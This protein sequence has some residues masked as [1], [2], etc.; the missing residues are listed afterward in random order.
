MFHALVEANLK[1]EYR[2]TWQQ[3]RQAIE[4]AKIRREPFAFNVRIKR[5]IV[6][7]A[8]AL[9]INQ[10]E[11]PKI[12]LVQKFKDLAKD[13]SAHK[14]TIE[15]R[16]VGRKLVHSLTPA[17]VELQRMS[18]AVPNTQTQPLQKD[19][20][21]L[22]AYLAHK[23]KLPASYAAQ[24]AAAGELVATG[25]MGYEDATRAIVQDK[26][27]LYDRVNNA[28]G[29]AA[30]FYSESEVRSAFTV[31]G[32]Y[33]PDGPVV[34]ASSYGDAALARDAT[35]GKISVVSG[36]NDKNTA[37]I[38]KDWRETSSKREF[39]RLADKDVPAPTVSLTATVRPPEN[40]AGAQTWQDY[41]KSYGADAVAS[42]MRQSYKQEFRQSQ[43]APT[44]KM[45]M[46]K[47]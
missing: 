45:S 21:S 36:Y 30:R 13:F 25:K 3:T 27:Y 18:D 37:E 15:Q 23:N 7:A 10:F 20:E 44:Q 40:A 46:A 14:N 42:N 6:A 1:D 12:D 38:M 47:D 19:H 34:F 2:R 41:T 11:P 8:L 9:K 31:V 26:V 33:R 39:V 35:A 22:G 29:D 4:Q 32:P 17:L 16:L 5:Q 24:I 43:T 28:V